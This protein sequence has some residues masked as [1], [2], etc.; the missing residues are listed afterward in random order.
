MIKLGIRKNER[1]G[2]KIFLLPFYAK[3]TVRIFAMGKIFPNMK[4]FK[5]LQLYKQLNF[6]IN[7]N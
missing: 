2:G 7:V 4:V 6:N 5:N 3:G 1:I